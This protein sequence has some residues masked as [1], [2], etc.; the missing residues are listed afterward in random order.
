MKV[1]ETDIFPF[2]FC[3]AEYK[4]YKGVKET[5]VDWDGDEIMFSEGAM[6]FVAR[7][8]FKDSGKIC[9]LIVINKREANMGTVAHEAFHSAE[10]V[11]ENIGIFHNSGSSEVY[12]YVIGFIAQKIYETIWE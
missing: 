8:K 11:L 1:F 5:F 10:N 2:R 4:E 7:A 6:G 12:A 3:I 9:S